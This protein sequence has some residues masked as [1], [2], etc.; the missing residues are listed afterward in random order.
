MS[1][2][3][4]ENLSYFLLSLKVVSINLKFVKDVGSSCHHFCPI[5]DQGVGSLTCWGQSA[6]GY[7]KYLSP[8][9]KGTISSHERSTFFSS[10][11][12]QHTQ[13][14]SADN[15]VAWGKMAAFRRFAN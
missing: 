8:L 15:P 11:D 3:V 9:I 2:I 1:R 14:Q 5:L 13:R 6:A 7:C 12:Y 10:F 4:R